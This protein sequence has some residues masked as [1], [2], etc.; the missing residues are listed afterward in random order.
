MDKLKEE[1]L[2]PVI[3]SCQKKF[4]RNLLNSTEIDSGFG[5]ADVVFYSLDKKTVNNRVHSKFLPIDSF[6]IIKILT[7]LNSLNSHKLNL[8]YLDQSFSNS[9][10]KKDKIISFL[11]EK[12][13]LIPNPNDSNE[14]WIA[15]NYKIGLKEVVAVEAKLSNW[16]RGLYQ[17]YRY[18]EYA[19][20]SYLALHSKYVHRA[21]KNIEDFKRFNI[22]LIEVNSNSIEIL[23]EPRREDNKDN[24]YSAL[25]YEGLLSRSE[26]FTPLV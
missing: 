18:K 21:L 6:E 23:Y 15:N 10:K 7:K 4:G 12:K 2:L 17:A 19:N 20:K 26:Y 8:T 11:V 14:F 9:K 22:G 13:F 24:I 3:K 16:K 5:I 25:V 1:E